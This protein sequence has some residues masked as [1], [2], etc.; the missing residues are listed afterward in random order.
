VA[1][2]QVERLAVSNAGVSAS[3]LPPRDAV[4]DAGVGGAAFESGEGVRAGI[5][6]GDV[7]T[8]LGER[9]GEAS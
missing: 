2:D 4:G 8:E 3:P 7:V 6:D 9:D 5:D 1:A